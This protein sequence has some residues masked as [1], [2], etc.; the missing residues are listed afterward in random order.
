MNLYYAMR[1][2]CW[3]PWVDGRCNDSLDIFWLKDDALADS[4]NLPPPGVIA[5][6]IVEDLQAALEQFKLIAVDLGG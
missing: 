5:Q 3:R 1:K 2:R 4:D 6:E